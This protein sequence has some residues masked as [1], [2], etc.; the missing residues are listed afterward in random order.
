M[1][2]EF[3]RIKHGYEHRLEMDLYNIEQ[4]INDLKNLITEKENENASW[5]TGY[6]KSHNWLNYLVVL[7]TNYCVVLH[8]VLHVLQI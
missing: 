1:E 8:V 2:E 5:K 3:E 7:C 4:E 6:F